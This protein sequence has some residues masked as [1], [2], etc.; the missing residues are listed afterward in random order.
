MALAQRRAL[1]CPAF[2]VYSINVDL[3]ATDNLYHLPNLLNGL[4]KLSREGKTRVR[5]SIGSAVRVLECLMA[6]AYSIIS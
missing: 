4:F 6:I 3:S 5:F 1:S 2:R